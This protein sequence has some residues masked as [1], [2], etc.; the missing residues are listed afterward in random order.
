MENQN[1][2]LLAPFLPTLSRKREPDHSF[3]HKYKGFGRFPSHCKVEIW[4]DGRYAVVMFTELESNKGTS[5]TNAAE[6]IVQEVYNLH[7]TSFLKECVLFVETYPYHKHVDMILPEWSG[8]NVIRV[9]WTHLGK[10]L[11]D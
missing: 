7:L 3:V 2:E 6:I 10:L 11:P 8:R 5:I 1:A 4:K 9:G